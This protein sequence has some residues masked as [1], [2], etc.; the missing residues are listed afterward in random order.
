LCAESSGRV[1]W[2][3]TVWVLEVVL[4]GVMAVVA[5]AV[6]WFPI[7]EMPPPR[8]AE[9]QALLWV[10]AVAMAGSGAAMAVLAAGMAWALLRHWRWAIFFGAGV[11]RIAWLAHA[12]RAFVV[13]PLQTVLLVRAGEL[14]AECRGS[15][16][17]AAGCDR[18]ALAEF[19]GDLSLFLVMDWV[20][21]ASSFL[22]TV[23]SWRCAGRGA[24]VDLV[25]GPTR[26]SSLRP[27]RGV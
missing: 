8:R 1:K 16:A 21:M 27:R 18:W 5:A 25:W 13:L 12:A 6:L 22:L 23:R 19:G 9:M 2:A 24:L 11:L 20:L 3:V 14:L 4:A 15:A 17:A 10:L 26:G 7:P